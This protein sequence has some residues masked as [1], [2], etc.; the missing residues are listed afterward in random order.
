MKIAI[1]SD[2]HLEFASIKLENPGD[3]DALILSGDIMLG[4]VLPQNKTDA[5]SRTLRSRFTAFFEQVSRD[6]PRVLYVM[7]NHEHYNGDFPITAG[8]IQGF[9]TRNNFDN[10]TLLDKQTARLGEYLVFGA[11]LWTDFNKEDPLSMLEVA[12]YM[13]DYR[14]IEDSRRVYVPEPYSRSYDR[15]TQLRPQ[16]TLLEH[17]QT[18]IS[19][20]KAA[21]IQEPM[22]VI[23]HHSPSFQSVHE[24]YRLDKYV[25]GAYHSSLEHIMEEYPNIKLWTHGHTHFPF[26]YEVFSTRVVCNPRGYHGYE[27]AAQDFKL[28]VVEL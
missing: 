2:L 19:L 20:R 8:Q 3:V 12:R 14:V 23:G 7:G 10:V 28:K 22:I 17:K 18:L 13:N 25:N 27:A 1:A 5:Q 4:C 15:K 11:T 9:L 16:D 21:E 24:D 6:F 26:D